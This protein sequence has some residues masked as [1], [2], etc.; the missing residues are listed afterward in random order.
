MGLDID[1]MNTKSLQ[2]NDTQ[3]APITIGRRVV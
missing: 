1:S 3:E 2:V